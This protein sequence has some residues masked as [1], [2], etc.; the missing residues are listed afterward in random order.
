MLRRIRLVTAI[1]LLAAGVASAQRG[2]LGGFGG[3]GAFAV[4]SGGAAALG[5]AGVEAC[6]FCSGRFALFGEYSHWFSGNGASSPF[7]AD[8]L[9]SAD[10]DGAGLRIQS[11]TRLRIF[12]DVGVVVGED[13]HATGR[14]GAIGGFVLGTGVEIPL[15]ERVYI[16][17][18]FRA[19][20]LSPHS[21]EGVDA[22]WAASGGVGFGYRF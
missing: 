16:R 6:V 5:Q 19:Y 18:Q 22:H 14:G 7:A 3:G 20:G 13:Q 17:P 4:S 15:G 11:R 8:R 1:T 21:L 2:E 12:F 10:L 9:S